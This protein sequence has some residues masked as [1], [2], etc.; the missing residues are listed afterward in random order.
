MF[1]GGCFWSMERPF[2]HVP[3]VIATTVGYA[4]GRT[5]NPTYEQVNTRT[6]GHAETVQVEFDP[7]KVSY[8]KLLDVYW[9][10]I[11]PV[12]KDRQFCDGGSDYRTIIFTRNPAQRSAAENSKIALDKSA[13]FKTRIVTEIV[14]NAR[15]WRGEEYHQHFADR[16]PDRY[17]AYKRGCGR[18]ARLHQL[19]GDAAAPYVPKG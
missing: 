4:G 2:A 1:A 6:T 13:H 14:A 18:D 12:T 17:N 10:N 5:A 3:G 9:H 7:S 8:E 19:W 11:D 15:F 16:N